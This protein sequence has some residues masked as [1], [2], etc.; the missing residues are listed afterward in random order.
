LRSPTYPNTSNS[1]T[2]WWNDLCAPDVDDLRLV[3]DELGL[4]EL[5]VEDAVH[6]RQRAK[7]PGTE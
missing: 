1:Q 3:A 4:H 7:L 2:H 6:P 5:A